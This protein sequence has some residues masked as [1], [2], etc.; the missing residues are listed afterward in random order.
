MKCVKHNSEIKNTDIKKK[1]KF[2]NIKLHNTK[3]KQKF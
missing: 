1:E 3:L 2:Y